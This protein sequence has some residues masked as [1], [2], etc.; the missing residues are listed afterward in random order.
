MNYLSFQIHGNAGHAGPAAMLADFLAS[1]ESL[2]AK[3]PPEMFAT[4][5]PGIA[6][7]DNIHPLFVHFPIAFFAGFF[8]LDLLGSWKD[9]P[10]WRYAAS[11]MLYLGTI[12]S[13][14]TV[15]AGFSA[16]DS[17]EHDEAV[18]DIMETHEHIGV[19]VLLLAFLL[20]FWRAKR[21]FKGSAFWNRVFLGLSAGLCL[22]ISFGAD[23]GGLMVYGHGVGTRTLVKS[24]DF[25]QNRA[26][27]AQ[28]DND[29][30]EKHDHHDHGGHGHEGHHHSHQ[31]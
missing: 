5:L 15:L 10:Q 3:S 2:L 18:H 14:F 23:L 27:P 4:L 7:M 22:L 30:G 31:D 12:M 25:S 20:T 19:Y 1:L 26:I 29:S 6:S 17:V 28:E 9:K 16:A 24:Q 13:I 8:L 21:W 11:C